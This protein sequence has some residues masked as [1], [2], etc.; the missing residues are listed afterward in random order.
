MPIASL[1]RS[2]RWK[3]EQH[4]SLISI[5]YL[6]RL[7]RSF[8]SIAYLDRLPSGHWDQSS[9]GAAPDCIAP[10][11]TKSDT[12]WQ[13]NGV[14]WRPTL[15]A[16]ATKNTANCSPP[17][18]K[19][20]RTRPSAATDS[21]SS[22]SSFLLLLLLLPLQNG[23][24]P[25]P[26]SNSAATRTT[27]PG[28]TAPGTSAAPRTRKSGISASGTATVTANLRPGQRQTEDETRNKQKHQE[29]L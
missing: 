13:R 23:A 24:H 4:R 12:R 11:Y 5:A 27:A 26:D 1:G 25:S 21:S 16:A 2:A 15:H 8:I 7:S 9:A 20:P 29:H 22:S 3:Q 6:D 17:D 10:V 28:T 18:S 19:M 14:E